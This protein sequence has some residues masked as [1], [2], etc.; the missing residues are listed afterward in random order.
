[1]IIKP[2]LNKIIKLVPGLLGLSILIGLTGCD[3]SKS[4]SELLEEE[5]KACNWYLSNCRVVPEVP[6]DND[7]EVGKDA[8]FY[9]MNN[10][11]TVYMRVL[12]VGSETSRPKK[13]DTVYFLYMRANVNNMYNAKSMTG[14]WDGN[15]ENMN[16]AL[17]GTNFVYG[18]TTLSST[19]QYGTGLQ[20]PLDYLGYDCE[21]D[22]LVKSR[23]GLTNDVTGCQAYIYNIR[24]FKA[25]Y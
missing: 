24:Y 23:E 13:G 9:R 25:E 10:D 12:N 19:T 5:N 17:N 20:V 16:S 3:D 7:F 18:N 21:V 11:G 8:P 22:L 2:I 1:M 14:S 6:K 15:A 4:Y